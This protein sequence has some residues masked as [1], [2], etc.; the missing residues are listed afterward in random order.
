MNS[1]PTATDLINMLH[2]KCIVT[3]VCKGYSGSR[4]EQLSA[5]RSVEFHDW[6]KFQWE[7]NCS[8]MQHQD[9]INCFSFFQL[10]LHAHPIHRFE[11]LSRHPDEIIRLLQQVQLF[12][13]V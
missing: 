2:Q 12:C 4:G 7:S 3:H 9:W 6:H 13:R 10:L 1:R 5:V 11:L 8:A